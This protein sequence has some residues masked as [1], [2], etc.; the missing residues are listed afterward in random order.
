M[1]K[2]VGFFMMMLAVVLTSCVLVEVSNIDPVFVTAGQ[3]A[4][5]LLAG[6]LSNYD[7]DAPTTLPSV[8]VYV[9]ITGDVLDKLSNPRLVLDGQEIAVTNDP[10][11]SLVGGANTAAVT[12][13]PTQ[14]ISFLAGQ[15]KELTILIDIDS[16]TLDQTVIQASTALIAGL[17]AEQG[18][19][20]DQLFGPQITVLQSGEDCF[21]PVASPQYIGLARGGVY[22]FVVANDRLYLND[23]SRG[24]KVFDLTALPNIVLERTLMPPVTS[25]RFAV[26]DYVYL[27]INDVFYVVDL[28]TGAQL[29]SVD[30]QF[31]ASDLFLWQGYAYLPQNSVIDLADPTNP[32]VVTSL[33]GMW[34]DFH[35]CFSDGKLFTTTYTETKVYVCDGPNVTLYTTLPV[36]LMVASSYD[37]TVIGIDAASGN[38]VIYDISDPALPQVKGTLGATSVGFDIL[39]NPCGYYYR[40]NASQG[41]EIWDIANQLLVGTINYSYASKMAVYKRYLLSQYSG[42]GVKIYDILHGD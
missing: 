20:L 10:G 1:G 26:G 42:S 29:G 19:Q 21:T 34:T 33:Y 11:Q 3:Q 5:T 41:T 39:A 30:T 23:W 9:N 14:P 24:I 31:G 40:R 35:E 6:Q 15:I 32:R 36:V 22:D 17:S 25:P 7:A 2:R 13:I 27:F 28:Q 16:A 8:T 12:F 4:V 38:H 37:S 18:I